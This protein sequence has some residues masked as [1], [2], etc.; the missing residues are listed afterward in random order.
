[1]ATVTIPNFEVT[2]IYPDS[3]TWFAGAFES[4]DYAN[5]WVTKAQLDPNWDPETQVQIVD[6][7]YTIDQP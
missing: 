5:A 1:M 3:T 2:L 6:K 4:L 7:S